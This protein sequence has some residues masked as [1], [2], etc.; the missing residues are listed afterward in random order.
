MQTFF[1]CDSS[2]ASIGGIPCRRDHNLTINPR[3]SSPAPAPAPSNTVLLVRPTLPVCWDDHHRISPAGTAEEQRRPRRGDQKGF[4]ALIPVECREAYRLQ[5]R[6]TPR[7]GQCIFCS[8]AC[9]KLDSHRC[10]LSASPCR[11]LLV[12]RIDLERRRPNA[13]SSL[14]PRLRGTF[15][16]MSVR[17]LH[18]VH[19]AIAQVVGAS[20]SYSRYAYSDGQLD[21]AKAR[22]TQQSSL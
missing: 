6:G 20:K 10:R 18:T 2:S 9:S 21:Q 7:G 3:L 15:S 14:Q 4:D 8:G 19:D 22:T 12:V 17:E 1:K 13:I 11:S 5:R 16:T